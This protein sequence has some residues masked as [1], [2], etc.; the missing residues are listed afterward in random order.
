M[1]IQG[2]KLRKKCW[3]GEKKD[4]STSAK[5]KNQDVGTHEKNA[6]L[7]AYLKC[8]KVKKKKKEG[9][10]VGARAGSTKRRR[11]ESPSSHH[12]CADLKRRRALR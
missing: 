3:A 4:S 8:K 6:E 1:P 11:S 2:R 5:T 9:G 12:F 7:L 10:R